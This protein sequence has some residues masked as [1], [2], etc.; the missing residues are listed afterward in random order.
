VPPRLL[1]SSGGDLQVVV[2]ALKRD[3]GVQYVYC[4]HAMQGFWGGLGL[5]DP[6]MAKYQV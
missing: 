1:Q 5:Q 2:A 3:H 4:W 6:L